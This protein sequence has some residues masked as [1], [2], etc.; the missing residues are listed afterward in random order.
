MVRTYSFILIYYTL[1]MVPVVVTS[2]SLFCRM[3]EDFMGLY[4]VRE[5]FKSDMCL[6]R[7]F[8]IIYEYIPFCLQKDDNHGAISGK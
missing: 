7:E 1:V 8:C 6:V 5:Q 4:L 2:F 3:K